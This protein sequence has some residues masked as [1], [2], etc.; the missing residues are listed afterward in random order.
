MYRTGN[1]VKRLRSGFNVGPGSASKLGKISG[2][3]IPNPITIYLQT[4]MSYLLALGNTM[5]KN[6]PDEEKQGKIN[7][8]MINGL[9]RFTT[10][11]T[12]TSGI[13]MDPQH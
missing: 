5:H 11:Q 3:E 8:L 4:A 7:T 9:L 1:C 2:S 13:W 12:K 10:G 6:L